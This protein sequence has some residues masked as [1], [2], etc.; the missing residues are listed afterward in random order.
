MPSTTASNEPVLLHERCC[1]Y[2]HKIFYL[3]KSCDRG[4]RYCSSHC[5]DE[6]RRLQHRR[7]SARHQCTPAGREGHRDYQRA[8]RE[9]LRARSAIPPVTDQSSNFS[10]SGSSCGSDPTRPSPHS[11]SNPHPPTHTKHPRHMALPPLRCLVC[12]RPGYLQKRDP[13]EPHYPKKQ[14]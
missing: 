14:P 10:D 7:A 9:R 11:H 12:G 5:R 8:Y 2:C 13:D 4:Q 3:C 6:A 1:R